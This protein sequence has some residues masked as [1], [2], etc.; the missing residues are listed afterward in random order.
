MHN[1]HINQVNAHQAKCM[2]KSE[3]TNERTGDR[4]SKRMRNKRRIRKA[5]ESNRDRLWRTLSKS[6]RQDVS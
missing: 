5:K 6:G 2:E 1:K 3:R 4:G